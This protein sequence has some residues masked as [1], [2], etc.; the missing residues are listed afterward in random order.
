MIK[1]L[2]KNDACVG[3][4]DIE[5]PKGWEWEDDWNIDLSRAVDEEGNFSAY[6][7][8]LHV[9]PESAAHHVLIT[10]ILLKHMPAFRTGWEYCVEVTLGGYGPVEKTYHMCRR[11]RWVRSRKLLKDTKQEA[12]VVRLHFSQTFV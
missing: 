3:R 10:I 1:S 12:E 8:F 11:R 5:L 7:L 9:L 6:P 4:D 2:Q